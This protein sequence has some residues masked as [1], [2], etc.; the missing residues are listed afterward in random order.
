MLVHLK[1]R[2]RITQLIFLTWSKWQTPMYVGSAPTAHSTD[3][4]VE[5]YCDDGDLR[6]SNL[7]SFLLWVGTGWRCR[8]IWLSIRT[9]CHLLI[10]RATLLAPMCVTQCVL[11]LQSDRHTRA[12]VQGTARWFLCRLNSRCKLGGA[13]YREMPFWRFAPNTNI[14]PRYHKNMLT[15]LKICAPM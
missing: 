10:H 12:C 7:D 1:I 13:S 8:G 14:A 11:L 9:H 6:H 4:K 15:C 2:I 3:K 5:I